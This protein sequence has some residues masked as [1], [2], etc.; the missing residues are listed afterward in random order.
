GLFIGT[1]LFLHFGLGRHEIIVEKEDHMNI[2]RYF[3]TIFANE[4]MYPVGLGCARLS[5]A[6]LYYRIFGLFG[7][8][9]YLYGVIAFIFAWT[10]YA[11]IPTIAAC[12]PIET[13]WTTRRNCIDL[14]RLYISTAVGSIITDFTLIILPIHYTIRLRLST[15]K[16][17]LLVLT[18]IFS[19]F[20][21]FITIIRLVKITLFD[22]VDPTWGT[23]DLMIWT[24]LEAYW[25]VYYYANF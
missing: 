25:Y 18:F 16:K 10:I 6:V 1:M 9:Y 4:I 8:R 22:F 23:V 14:A 3:Q 2:R 17:I 7:A 21:C 15:S 19:G 5:L 24:G 13:F 20:N 11:S 12:T